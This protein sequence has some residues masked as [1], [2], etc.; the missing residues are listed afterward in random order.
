TSLHYSSK[1]F[2]QNKWY[3]IGEDNFLIHI[4]AYKHQKL[5]SRCSLEGSIFDTLFTLMSIFFGV[6]EIKLI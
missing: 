4:I 3:T 2:F 5:I 1:V 6:A